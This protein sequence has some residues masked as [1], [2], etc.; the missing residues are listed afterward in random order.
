MLYEYLF[1]LK[2]DLVG[3]DYLT[4]VLLFILIFYVIILFFSC[5]LNIVNYYKRFQEKKK[6]IEYEKNLIQIKMQYDTQKIS[7]VIYKEK[8]K[9]IIN[10]IRKYE[11]K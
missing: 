1:F 11:H 6:L 8:T 3:L 4:R 5:L 7:S 10:L 2:E 9:K